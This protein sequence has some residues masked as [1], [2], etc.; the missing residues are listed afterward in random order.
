M[1]SILFSFFSM[2]CEMAPYLMIGFL[3]AG[4]LHVFVPQGVFE[5]YLGQ[6]N[7]KSVLWATLLGIPLPLCSCGV[8]P[9]AVSLRRDGA[10]RGATVAFMIATPQT[11]VDSI[12]ATYS[13]LGLPFAILRPVVALIT[14]LAGGCVTAQFS[15]DEIVVHNNTSKHVEKRSFGQKI[16]DLLYYSFIEMFQNIGKWLIIGLALGALITVFVPD[17]F[18]ASLNLPPIVMMMLV[19]VIAIPMYVCTMGSIPIAAALILKGLTPGTALVFLVAGPAA[20]IANILI[21][22]K[23]LGRKNLICYMASII[24]G[25][26]AGGIV[27]DYLLPASWFMPAFIDHA[28]CHTTQWPSVSQM[29]FCGIFVLLLANAFILKYKKNKTTMNKDQIIY[30]IGGMSCNHCKMSVE[31]AISQLDGVTKVEVDLGHNLA[32]VTG[33]PDDEAVKKAVEEIGFEY[34]GKKEE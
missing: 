26:L 32:I 25:A 29:I 4:I 11:G 20:S 3:I 17:N 15:K 5:K 12:I 30:Q 2:L 28:C 1:S 16:K 22:G 8:I 24:I 18:F 34:N 31:K 14:G 21:I 23:T 10:S 7:F 19:L 33:T 13:M 9:T 27:V 6:E